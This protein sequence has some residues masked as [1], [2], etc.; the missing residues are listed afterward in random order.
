MLKCCFAD[1]DVFVNVSNV[2]CIELTNT[3]ID[4][5]QTHT[6]YYMHC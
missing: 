4:V 1:E 5:G 3:N 6:M 2:G